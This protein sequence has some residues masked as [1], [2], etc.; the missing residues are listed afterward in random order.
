MA[1]FLGELSTSTG[2]EI[3]NVTPPNE[4]I[5]DWFHG[6]ASITRPEDVHHMLGFG[7]SDAAYGNH[8]HDGKASLTLIQPPGSII[9]VDL[10]ATPATSDIVA[11][12]NGL[13]A[14]ARTILGAG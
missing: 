7:P 6:K 3:A 11:A 1:N 9:L 4:K 8:V 5:V 12:V 10:T 13:N 2:A 14:M